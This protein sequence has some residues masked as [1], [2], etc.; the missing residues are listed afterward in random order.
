MVQIV[1]IIAALALLSFAFG[2]FGNIPPTPD[3]LTGTSDSLVDLI[4]WPIQIMAGLIG[5]HLFFGTIILIGVVMAWEPIY[6]L[7]IWVLRKIPI[8][9]IK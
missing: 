1:L 6:H 9:G 5:A 7:V 4:V 8:L 3:W 2:I